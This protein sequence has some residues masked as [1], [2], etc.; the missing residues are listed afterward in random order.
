MNNRTVDNVYSS[1]KYKGGSKNRA[2]EGSEQKF[3][4]DRDKSFGTLLSI[5]ILHCIDKRI[6]PHNFKSVFMP[7]NAVRRNRHPCCV[8]SLQN[9]L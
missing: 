2:D 6:P 5:H 4:S 3:C 9:K 1:F 7:R 8:P